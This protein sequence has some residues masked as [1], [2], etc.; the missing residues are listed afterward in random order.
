V[1]ERGVRRVRPEPVD[2]DFRRHA[3]RI[4]VG[5]AL[6]AGHDLVVLVRVDRH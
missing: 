6:L 5:E 2:E 4:D 3:V 1:L